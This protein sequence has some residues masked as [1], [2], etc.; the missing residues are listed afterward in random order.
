MCVLCVSFESKV[1]PRSIEGGAMGSAM[2]VI[3][4]S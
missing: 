2:L 4:R 3:L 1:K